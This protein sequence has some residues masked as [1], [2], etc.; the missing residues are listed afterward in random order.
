LLPLSPPPP[1]PLLPLL[2]LLLLL[3]LLL[4][5]DSDPDAVSSADAS[6][7]GRRSSSFGDAG[8][9]AIFL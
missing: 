9:S 1:L 6:S 3:V 2:P 8:E 4:P 5:D 7:A